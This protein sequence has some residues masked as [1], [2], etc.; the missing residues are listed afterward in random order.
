MEGS[1]KG[2][3]RGLKQLMSESVVLSGLTGSTSVAG[4]YTNTKV[5]L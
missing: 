4:L 3:A 5:S 2:F 1:D